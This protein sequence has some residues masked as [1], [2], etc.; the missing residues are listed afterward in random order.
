[1]N[2][3]LLERMAEAA[4]DIF[5]EDL[6]SKGYSLGTSNDDEQKIH[7]SLRPYADLP[8]S[9][10]EQN[11]SNVRDIANK[12]GLAGYVMMP[13]RSNEPPFNFPGPDLEQLAELEHDRWMRLK[14]E[15]GWRYAPTTDKNDKL[16]NAL[17]PWR[18][19]PAAERT[20][21]YAAYDG[22]VGDGPLPELEKEKDRTLVRGIPRILSRAGYTVVKVAQ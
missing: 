22:A 17:M 13:A 11:R 3:E 12:L 9:E 15:S 10:K 1:L 16:H 19:L 6:R 2:G 5:C 18:K 20:R 7:S 21:V 14:L 4:H 8:E